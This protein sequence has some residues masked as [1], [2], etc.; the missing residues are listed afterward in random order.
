MSNFSNTDDTIDSRD[1]IERIEEL[2]AE[3]EELESAVNDPESDDETADAIA[4]LAAWD[5]DNLEELETLQA[6]A[7]EAEDSPDWVHGETLINE[8]YFTDYIE[9]LIN[10]CY[11]MPKQMHSGDWPYRHM[12]ID[13]E[14]AAEEAKVDYT[15]VTFDGNVYLIR[16]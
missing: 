5:A 4:A 12:I 3:R 6:L 7:S 13:Y 10:D 15:E 11:E 2:E 16:A 8:S 1:I 14:A 9:E